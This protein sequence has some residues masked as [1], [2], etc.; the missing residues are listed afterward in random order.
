MATV[1]IGGVRVVLSMNAGEFTRGARQAGQAMQTLGTQIQNISES[2]N[3]SSILVNTGIMAAQRFA[4]VSQSIINVAS[5]FEK[6]MSNV[7][8]LI[9]TSRESMSKMSEE[10]QA[11]GRRTPVALADL[12][13]GL[14]DMRSA[15][16]GAEDAMKLLEGS[17]RLGVAALGTTAETVDIV[18][19][20][21]NA[22]SLKG[23]DTE[24]VLDLL[25][26]TTNYGKTTISGLARGFGAVAGT[27]AQAG[28][29]L[30]EYLA[31][32]SAMTT[33]GLPAAEAHTQLRAAISG[34]TRESELG[35]Q[36]LDQL[37]AK[38]FKD[39][40][41]QSGGLVSA[42]TRI[43]N[44]LQG[45]DAQIQKLLGSTEAYNALISLTGKQ[46]A[47]YTN[48][49]K[50]MR[51][52]AEQLGPAFEKQN[53]TIFAATQRLMTNIEVLGIAMGN[54]LAPAI[55]ALEKF[56]ADLTTAF[57]SLDPETQATIA[58]IGVLVAVIGPAVIALGFFVNA[59]ASLIPVFVGVAG[60]IASVGALIAGLIMSTGPIGAFVIV[61]SAAVTAWNIF[62]DSIISIFET[63]GRF[64][65]EK[66]DGIIAK[67]T[68]LGTV[69]SNVFGAIASGDFTKAW[70]EINAAMGGATGGVSEHTK[71]VEG[72]TS[73]W[74]TF[75]EETP[76]SFNDGFVVPMTKGLTDMEKLIKRATTE[77]LQN[78]KQTI[79]DIQDPNERL[80]DQQN[81]LKASLDAGGLTAEQ[82]GVAMQ[83]AA[84]VSVNAYAGMAS[85]IAQNLASA[86]G[87][88]KGF[89]IA[90]ALMN[91]F[92]SVT[93]SLATYGFTPWG[94]AAAAAA[95]A[96]GLAQVANIRKTTKGGGGG[97]S[98]GGGFSGGS[99][100]GAGAMPQQLMVQ[101]ISPGQ[102][103]SGDVVKQLANKLLDFQ[104]D[105]GQVVIQ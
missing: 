104:R 39:L 8:T 45:N 51:T 7:S 72:M 99:T 88:S 27:V 22:F 85:G 16:I 26:K 55:K 58:Q 81:R 92:E 63:I 67:L 91:T 48:T 69:I 73:A 65:S 23:E 97:S 68:Q 102:M 66:I 37:G 31:S 101:G 70:E 35:R 89:A 93:K 90:A 64:I 52:G 5:S 41:K 47:S 96:A 98:G 54:A 78:A 10:V 20:A 25:F 103:F 11:I 60:A 87:N 82:Y 28:I 43:R 71:S 12:T 80:I 95:S 56:V 29:Q 30:D 76:K 42:F 17:A 13:Q 83:K 105:G 36:V 33:V 40:I 46:N 3:R 6:G 18:T 14:Y 84:A 74:K 34:M 59:L 79:K 32:V 49:L 15:G 50:E 21:I 100:A 77:A 24:R 94:I 44:T 86:F 62:K 75:I 9:D 19:S 4:Q 38:S 53:D 61:A 57:K 1:E 2:I